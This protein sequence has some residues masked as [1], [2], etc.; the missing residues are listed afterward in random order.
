MKQSELIKEKKSFSHKYEVGIM[1]EVP[2]SAIQSNVL[3][4]MLIYVNWN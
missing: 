2:A 4:N 1:I 3:S